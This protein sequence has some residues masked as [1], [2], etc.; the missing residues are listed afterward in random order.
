MEKTITH[1]GYTFELVDRIP[2]GYLVW[3]IGKHM[4]DGYLPLCR[5]AYFQP[6]PGGRSIENET[7]KAIKCEGAQ[8]ILE[9]I[10]WGPETPEEMER[11]IEKF[12]REGTHTMEFERMKKA[13][14]L[15]RQ[16]W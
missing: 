1:N 12:E 8:T 16:I 11:Y 7:L 10:G 6:F 3:N 2:Q 15:M 4:I 9:A 13:V 14:P 5:L